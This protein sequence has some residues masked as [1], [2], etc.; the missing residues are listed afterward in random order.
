MWSEPPGASTVLA[1]AAA[2]GRAA[3]PRQLERVRALL[4]KAEST[5]FAEE[6][7]AYTAKAQELMARHSIDYAL[8]SVG[9]GIRD[10]PVGRRIGI[11]NPYA[12]PK[13]LLHAAA[14]GANRCRA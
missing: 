1:T 6:A 2:G 4:A 3:D 13:V 12:A 7:E 14:A 11:D 10:Q 9:T 8:L 5:S